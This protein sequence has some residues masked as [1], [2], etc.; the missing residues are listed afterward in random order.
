MGAPTDDDPMEKAKRYGYWL[1][2]IFGMYAVWH[3]LWLH[4]CT[5][6]T[7]AT[8]GKIRIRGG[9]NSGQSAY[10]RFLYT[11]LCS[12]RHNKHNPWLRP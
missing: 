7:S 9:K 6:H 5:V 1:A 4:K 3:V 12:N 2:C 11:S 8:Q 10:M